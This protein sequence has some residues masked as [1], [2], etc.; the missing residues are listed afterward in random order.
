MHSQLVCIRAQDGI[1]STHGIELASEERCA[2]ELS[3]TLI[4]GMILEE[5]AFVFQGSIDGFRRFN[6]PLTAIHDGNIS[7]T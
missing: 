1:D 6:I 2:T 4:R 5:L 3:L 7:E